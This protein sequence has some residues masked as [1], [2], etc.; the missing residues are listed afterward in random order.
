MSECP[1][2][3]YMDGSGRNEELPGHDDSPYG[4][5]LFAHL[6]ATCGWHPTINVFQNGSTAALFIDINFCPICGRDLRKVME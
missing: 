1:Y 5:E 3:K 4:E 2:C 6:S